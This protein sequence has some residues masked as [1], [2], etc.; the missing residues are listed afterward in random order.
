MIVYLHDQEPMLSLKEIARIVDLSYSCVKATM[1]KIHE[2]E[3]MGL[4]AFEE[5]KKGRKAKTTP[6]MAQMVKAHLTESRTATLSTARQMLEDAGV[7][8]R[9]TSVWKL[10]HMESL[11]Y[12][13]TALK[14]EITW[15]ERVIESR[16]QY[17][18]RVNA[19]PDDELFFLDETG[20]NLHVSVTRAWSEVGQTPVVVVPTNKGQNVSALVCISTAGV[21]TM[22]I[23]DGAFNSADFLVFLTDLAHQFQELLRGEA[24]IVMDN[25]KIHH[26]ADVIQ[27]LE[28]NGIRYQFLPP[29]SPE[30]NP[31]EL[32]FG[33][34]K[35]A[36]RRDGP[37]QTRGEMKGRIRATFQTVDEQ[38]DL[39]RYYAHAREFVAKAMNREPFF[40]VN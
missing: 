32:L 12:K 24:V 5:V 18:M 20:F 27:F 8:V 17:A 13:R 30:L 7:T 15:T 16:F 40:F 33:T 4:D 34:V 1:K 28:E 19:M 25:A 23:K 3:E 39:R 22:T 6:E 38:V 21:K 10:A 26:A 9:K 31:I 2:R 37:A 14:G 11:S 29:Y 35:A 36:Y